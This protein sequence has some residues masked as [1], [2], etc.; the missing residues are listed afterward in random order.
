MQFIRKYETRS[1]TRNRELACSID[2]R[3]WRQIQDRKKKR[4]KRT[5]QEKNIQFCFCETTLFVSFLAHACSISSSSD[6]C[7]NGPLSS[8]V[9]IGVAFDAS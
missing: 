2:L 6:N 9:K 8:I 1:L 7:S 4:N 3:A 5:E